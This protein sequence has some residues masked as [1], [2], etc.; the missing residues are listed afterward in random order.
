MQ[1]TSSIGSATIILTIFGLIAKATGFFREVLFAN[2]FG[3][4]REYEFYLVAS[5]LPITL[6]SIA[7]YIYQNYFIPAYSKREIL[8]YEHSAD[9][10][11]KT[12]LNSLLIALFT[13]SI[14]ILF[15][16]PIIKIY[17]GNKLVSDKIEIL[18]I[19]FSLTVPLS[20]VSGFLIAYLQTQFNFKSPAVA[21][22]SLNIL[23]IL[24]LIIFKETNII[25]IAYSYLSGVLIQTIVLLKVSNIL[26]LL[27]INL[28]RASEKVKSIDSTILWI[29]L[30]EVIGQLYIL[31]DRYFLSRVDEGGI[32]AINY[33]LTIF[34]LPI[35][36]ITIS[37]S[38]AVF[39]KFSQLAASNSKFELKDKIT[40]ALVSISLLFIPIN[41]IFIF[42]RKEVVRIFY[43]R[44]NFTFNSTQL[45]SDV[46]FYFSLSLIFYSLYGILNKIFYVYGKVKALFV[47][48]VLGI[49]LKI[50]L[51]FILV[52][53]L[54][55]NGL[56]ISTSLS[57]IFFFI[58]S[59]I[60]IHSLFKLIA[61]R[62]LV[63]KF[64]FYLVNGLFSFLIVHILFTLITIDTIL[65]D[66]I[67]IT[68]FLL[69]YYINNQVMNDK[70]QL[71]IQNEL[72][73]ILP[74]KLFKREI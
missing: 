38:T 42:W 65:F 72:I 7:L 67:K 23:T 33:A 31:S 60:I 61:F 46:L 39:P 43:E 30:I 28:N 49:A 4:S 55:Q 47:V 44:G 66:L 3:I 27:R 10:S 14:I 32:A 18:F 64:I 19:I 29:L 22:L 73:R 25:Y 35:S 71:E 41:L 53:S 70:Y 52:G 50:A 2:Y 9:F 20:I 12:F 8:G 1:K 16:I 57:Y 45:T 63:I 15:R 26:K 48:T 5:V 6:N 34:L 74:N 59:L 17:L 58:L 13:V 69:I 51:N 11:K 68:L 62:A 54:K 36:I 21:A 24:A 40:T 56:A 37:I